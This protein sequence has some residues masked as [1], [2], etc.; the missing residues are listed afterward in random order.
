[1]DSQASEQRRRR[2][3]E[4]GKPIPDDLWPPVLLPGA[5]EW[6]A[7][8]WELSTDRQIGFTTGPIPAASIDRR[9]AG[10]GGEEAA[11]FRTCIRAMDAAYMKAAMGEPEVPET[12]N[13]A[14]DAFR[15][16]MR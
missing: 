9:A 10:M 15:A 6:L 16:A 4:R 12:D 8:F 14:R 1:M 7:I 2:L 11:M 3:E 5:D 13:S